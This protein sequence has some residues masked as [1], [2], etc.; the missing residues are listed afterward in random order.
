MQRSSRSVFPT[1]A[2]DGVDG[3]RLSR[4]FHG[5]WVVGGAMVIQALQG[6]LFYQAFG[7][8][9]PF[10]MAEFGWSRTTISLIHSLHRSESG[11]LGPVHGWIIQRFGPQR[12]ILAGMALLGAGYVSLGFAQNFG[13]FMAAFMVMAIGSS[14][15]GF[16]SLMTLVVNWFARLRA[17]AMA[18]VAFGM[19]I[20]GLLVTVVA[21]LMVTYGW[22]AVAIGS[23][24]LFLLLAFPL[25]RVF[26]NDPESIGARP[27]GARPEAGETTTH[28]VTPGA[29]SA[30][31]VL[32]SPEFWLISIGHS[33][34]LAIV[35]AVSVH[36]V[37]FVG[38]AL[39]MSVTAAAAMFTLIVVCQMVGQA[40]GG[41]LG[42][43][44]DK[45][46]LAAGGM[47]MHSVAML[48]LITAASTAVVIAAAV[49]H[50]L[51]WGLRGPLMS[52]I[53]ADYFGRKAFAMVMGYS[54]LVIMVGAVLGPLIVGLLAD[55]RGDYGLAFGVLAAIG[56]VG[57]IA[58]LV[59]P[60][61]PAHHLA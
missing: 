59:M 33:S 45:R 2:R 8:Y 61:A 21:W 57:T 24:A 18:L 60:R 49:L 16:M 48:L 55:L 31:R 1:A 30:R 39:E 19:S 22:R 50:G 41:F 47:G 25:A 29:V 52:A 26:V 46:W 37:L 38:S 15:C 51:A 9:A 42:D 10:W 12:A 53:R 28:D 23:G 14:L 11:L 20:G 5:W 13:S 7:V 27:D 36:F 3:G 44:F 54:S 6:S 40:A 32:R 34:A 43:H 4:T 17:R 35:G 56:V 58:F